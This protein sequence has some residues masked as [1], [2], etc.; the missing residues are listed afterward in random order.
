MFKKAFK[1]LF[2]INSFLLPIVFVPTTNDSPTTHNQIK[3][4]KTRFDTFRFRSIIASFLLES[5]NIKISEDSLLIFTD[6]PRNICIDTGRSP[7]KILI[8]IQ[9]DTAR[10]STHL[11]VS[12]AMS[13]VK[14]N[15]F[16]QQEYIW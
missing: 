7:E 4:T 13:V 10:Y 3:E 15:I 5:R 11:P 9:R 1:Y 6:S 8:M 2:T 14:L 12:L 16:L